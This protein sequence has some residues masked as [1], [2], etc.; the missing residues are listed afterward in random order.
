M[1]M[2]L[3]SGE[4][5]R[6]CRGKPAFEREGGGNHKLHLQTFPRLSW[7][8]LWAT[9]VLMRLNKGVGGSAPFGVRKTRP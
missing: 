2:C 8:E 5:Y 9:R 7:A 6:F 1:N 3:Q 4:F